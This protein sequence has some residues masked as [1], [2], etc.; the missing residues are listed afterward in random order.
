MVVPTEAEIDYLCGVVSAYFRATIVTADVV[1][2]FAGVRAL[3][4]DGAR[5]PQDIGRDYTLVLD[6]GSG[7]A[8]LLT[9]YGGKLTTFRRLAE[10]VLSR[11]ASFFPPAR[12][13]TAN[14]SLPG[15]DFV[16]DGAA[17]LVERTQRQ[18]SFLSKEHAERLV[19]AYGTRV[20][21]ILQAAKR[22]EHLGRLLWVGSHRGRGALS[23]DQGM[24]ANR[25][26]RAL[27]AFQ[28]RLAR[29]GSSR[30][31]RSIAS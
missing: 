30:R 5:K 12:P 13:W 1:W 26:R 31:P 7:A 21:R 17:T 4:G 8:P 9:V 25:G 2:A 20:D 23:D 28:A 10:D 29:F 15:G 22:P 27:A 6:K 24:G 16:Y 3:Y 14:S 19:G 18:W 11:L